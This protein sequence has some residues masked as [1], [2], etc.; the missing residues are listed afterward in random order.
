[1]RQAVAAH[2]PMTYKVLFNGFVS[3]TGGQQVDGEMT[4]P[5]ILAQFA[6][7]G[8]RKMAVVTDEPAKYEGLKLPDGVPVHPRDQLDAVQREFREYKDVSVIVYDQPCATERRR[9]RKRGKWADPDLRTFINPAV[10][11]GCGDCGKQANC[12]SI[13]PLETELGRKRRINQSSCNK[14]FSCVD[15][16]CPSFVTVA[17]GKLRKS[18]QGAKATSTTASPQAS[19]ALPVAPAIDLPDPVFER[20]TDASYSILVTGIGGT[21]VVTIGQTLAVAAHLEGYFSSN[22]DVTGLS[23]KYGAV[24]S[25]IKLAPEARMLHATRIAAGEADALVGC[26]LIV[27]AGDESMARLSKG[28]TGGVVCT[29][30]VPTSEFARN[31]DWRADD[32]ALFAR[33]NDAADGKLQ[34]FE[35]L[36]LSK[37]L[38]GD[39]IGAN[40]MLLGAAWQM[41]RI[42]LS[43]AAIDRAIELN[44]VA[45]AMNKSAFDW[46][47][48]LVVDPDAVLRQAAPASHAAQAKVISLNRPRLQSLDDIVKHRR[49]LLTQYKNRGWALQILRPGRA[50]QR[51]RISAAR[52]CRQAGGGQGGGPQP[53]QADGAQGRVRGRPLVL[54][55]EEFR[56]E[57]DD[58]FEPGYTLRFHVAGGPFGKRDASG[59]LQ[60]AEVGPW[61]MTGFRWL[62]RMRFLRGGLLDV[63]RHSGRA[64]TGAQAAHRLR[65]RPGPDPRATQRAHTRRRAGTGELAGQ[66]AWLRTRARRA[67]APGRDRA[68]QAARQPAGRPEPAAAGGRDGAGGLRPRTPGD[69]SSDEVR[70]AGFCTQCRSRCGCVSVVRGQRLL[71][72]EPLPG[73][74][75]GEQLCPK[76]N[77]APELVYHPDRLT[78]PLRRTAPKGAADPGWQ[79]VSWDAALDE[80]AARMNGIRDTHGAEQVAFS[81]T[82]PSG[83]HMSDG[84]SWVERLVRAFGSPNNIYGTEICNWHKDFA[85]R[86]TF[87]HDIGTPDFANTDCILLWG[88][89]P[90]NT[91]LARAGEIRKALQRGAKIVVIDPQRTVF[92]RSA[93]SWLRVRPGTD[94]ALALGLAH[95]LI[96]TE[97]FDAAFVAQWTNGPLLV[98]DDTGRLLRES[99]L[100][101]QGRTDVALAA[102]IGETYCATTLATVGGWMSTRN[103]RC[104]RRQ[105]CASPMAGSAA[106]PRSR[107]TRRWPRNFHRSALPRSPA[108][109][110]RR[111]AL[112]PTCWPARHR[113]PGM[114]GTAS[115]RVRWPRRPIARSRCSTR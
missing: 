81:V 109:S 21:G 19:A 67:C 42:P 90:A 30:M 57:L 100:H 44:G 99:D 24:L 82:T 104:A 80:I 58:T 43:R 110:R 113:S 7:E 54:T 48:R 97:R 68:R 49:Q 60:K 41:G 1:M 46:G 114:P 77:A 9:L 96:S 98:R 69:M 25:H 108:S 15:G 3:M 101:G 52:Q 70:T 36:R 16:F 10:C 4:V 115:A 88:H 95:Q 56:K 5:G 66:G 6:A 47:R 62:A 59:R 105:R 65:V 12:L 23:Q 102:G 112:R 50:H 61:L 33:V 51:R 89:N 63:Y 92:A 86:F 40:M 78:H 111:W 20:P 45:V 8:V 55:S 76:G 13:E 32:K 94:Q 11:E 38:L 103:R 29:D 34:G 2:V 22:L 85:S 84:I 28:R 87:G 53:G 93:D 73:H 79:A 91:W 107:A 106:R 31:P 35:A 64:A 75:S 18:A 26:D 74:P 39:A 71:R 83:T 72:I 27:T 37:T 14:D 17:G